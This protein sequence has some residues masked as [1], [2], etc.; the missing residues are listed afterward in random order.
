MYKVLFLHGFFASG[1]CIPALTL[2]EAL[3]GIAEVV[4]PDLPIHPIQALD[5]IKDLCTKVQP[6]IIVG[7]SNGSFLA[8]ITAN[9]LKIPALLGNPHFEMTTFLQSRIGAHQY[10]SPRE[11]GIQNFTID[12]DLIREFDEL[13]KHQFDKCSESFRDKVWGLFGDND[14]LAHYEPL[15]LEHYSTSY[16]FP[17]NHT[18]T[19]EEVTSWYVPVIKKMLVTL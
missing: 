7:N 13:Q 14:T 4:T 10:K 3:K 17:G 6:D 5:Y 8:Q 16:H 11:N 12:E 18:P 1:S 19:A 2:K 9:E 15:F